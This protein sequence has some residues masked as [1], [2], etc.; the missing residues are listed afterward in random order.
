MGRNAV[1]ELVFFQPVEL[2]GVGIKWLLGSARKAGFKLETSPDGKQ[3]DTVFD[4]ES[5]G[6]TEDFEDVKFSRRPVWRLRFTGRGNSDN[7]WNS[8]VSLRL[9]P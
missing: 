1:F 6:K 9:L 4:G 7:A 8:I 2:S 3:Y 5:S